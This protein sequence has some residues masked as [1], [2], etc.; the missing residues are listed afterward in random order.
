MCVLE[1]KRAHVKVDNFA[2]QFE[3]KFRE[4]S[5]NFLFFASERNAKLVC[6]EKTVNK[7]PFNHMLNSAIQ[8]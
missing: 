2:K 5:E 7:Q 8:F 3:S 4:K 1:Y 6:K